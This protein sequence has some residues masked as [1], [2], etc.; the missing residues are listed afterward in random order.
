MFILMTTLAVYTYVLPYKDML[1]NI[2]E[3]LFQLSLLIFLMLRSTTNIVDNYLKFPNHQYDD[4]MDSKNCSSD[5]GTAY[6]TWVL[7]PFA[8]FP[9]V[10]IIAIFTVKMILRLW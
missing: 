3:L 4:D 2:I 5:T 6:L 8:Y 7:S 1:V 9:L 10:I